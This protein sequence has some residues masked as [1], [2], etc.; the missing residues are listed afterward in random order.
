MMSP[1]KDHTIILGNSKEI[2]L[3]PPHAEHTDC[4][5]ISYTTHIR[6]SPTYCPAFQLHILERNKPPV[7]ILPFPWI[8]G[9]WCSVESNV[10]DRIVFPAI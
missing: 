1:R 10:T 3:F 4:N 5:K 7:F 2:S 6:V 8:S 9:F